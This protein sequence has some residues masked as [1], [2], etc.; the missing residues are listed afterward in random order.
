[1]ANGDT[2]EAGLT[3]SHWLAATDRIYV[4]AAAFD[5]TRPLPHA[6]GA[7]PFRMSSTRSAP[8]RTAAA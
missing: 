5:G 8:A 7:R 1:M 6:T 4:S 2:S 3:I